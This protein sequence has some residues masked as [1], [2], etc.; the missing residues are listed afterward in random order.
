MKK[1]WIL[2]KKDILLWF[3]A[4]VFCGINF[5]RI[6]DSVYEGDELYSVLIVK[7]SISNI[8]NATAND[9][10]PPLHYLWL[11]LFYLVF[12]DC[13][14]AYHL[15]SYIP[16]ATTILICLT[17]VKSRF[18][19][20][21]SLITITLASLTTNAVR[22]N[23]EIRMYS[24]A[25]LFCF[26]SFLFLYE[27]MLEDNRK[28]YFLFILFS[29]CAAY[30]HYYNIV[31]VAFYYLT[32]LIWTCLRYHK[33][34]RKLLLTYLATILLY[35]PWL[36]ILFS[37]LQRSVK[38]WF[39][40]HITSVLECCWFVF[41][42]FKLLYLFLFFFTIFLLY[43]TNSLS[44]VKFPIDEN[45][46]KFSY[47]LRFAPPQF[48]ST[49]LF[50]LT[51]AGVISMAGTLAIGVIL[52]NVVRPL[53]YTRYTYGATTALFLVFGICISK[54]Y[55]KRTWCILLILFIFSQ[56]FG[57][58]VVTMRDERITNATMQW[59]LGKME[60]GSHYLLYNP[61]WPM[62]QFVQ[63]YFPDANKIVVYNEAEET[64]EQLANL[65]ESSYL[66]LNAE[67]SDD[68][69]EAISKEGYTLYFIFNTSLAYAPRYAYYAEHIK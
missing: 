10:H 45:S 8:C 32:L 14:W 4:I 20:I 39:S 50:I 57:A 62:T 2:E 15:A 46:D 26:L 64:V 3:I 69:I 6:F 52:S 25:A 60:V 33:I 35:V 42:N 63:Q 13:G 56:T 21:P 24:L 51:I 66:L 9:V 19:R 67:L 7:Y 40:Q 68:T 22:F 11:H 17:L 31:I 28:N 37:T 27:I 65:Q 1:K 12:G 18:G 48:R 44:I 30:T 55:F 38:E 59:Y 49:P 5:L 61:A 53:F 34:T 41:T 54:M 16:Y 36:A 47:R 23:L 29:I 58:F 43:S